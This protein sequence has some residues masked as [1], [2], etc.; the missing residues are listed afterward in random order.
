VKRFER[1]DQATTPDGTLLELFRHDGDYTIRVKGV[2]LMCS[3]RT[4][5]EE[6][7]SDVGCAPLQGRSG[8][9]VLI[10]GLGFGFTARAAL[11]WLA[12]DAEMVIS[13]LVEAVVRWNLNPE[14][15]LAADVL[16]D[17]RV[18]VRLED[19]AR[20]MER[21]KFD[22]ILLDVD[23]GAE[24]LT[25]SGN[26]LLYKR[27]GIRRAV[28]ALRPGG[29]LIYWLAGSDPSFQSALRA[30]GLEVEEQRIATYP[31]AGTRHSLFVARLP[32]TP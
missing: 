1:L 10:G 28:G 27:K 25:D 23:N 5:S 3:R 29:H 24:S 14:Y 4:L 16:A 20:T 12:P 26:A 32:G 9:R 7:M 2:E 30:E 31:G 15:P 11:R 19:V 6:R 17:P 21:E 18:T 22:A 13:E 8:A